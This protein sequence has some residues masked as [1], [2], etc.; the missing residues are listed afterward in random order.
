MDEDLDI[1]IEEGFDLLDEIEKNLMLAEKGESHWREAI[2]I[3]FGAIHTIKGNSLYL[4]LNLLSR[5]CQ[6]VESIL[7]DET[8]TPQ[9]PSQNEFDLLLE[10]VDLI[11]DYF[12]DIKEG[13]DLKSLD[14]ALINWLT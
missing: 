6:K 14:A 4:N 10:F 7:A 3:A 11:R 1:F 5:C 2:K 12:E 13:K 9:L 8:R